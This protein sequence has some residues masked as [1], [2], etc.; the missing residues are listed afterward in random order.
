MATPAAA[1]FAAV[2]PATDGV[3]SK[4]QRR[5]AKLI[6]SILIVAA[7]AVAALLAAAPSL[8][9]AASTDI[10]S[11]TP[12]SSSSTATQTTPPAMSAAC[13][14]AVDAFDASVNA[15]CV[16]KYQG[17]SESDM[18]KCDCSV[19]GLLGYAQAVVD[20]CDVIYR[21]SI[22][23]IGY[24]NINPTTSLADIQS[25]CA[26]YGVTVSGAFNNSRASTATATTTSTS[27]VALARGLH[28]EMMIL[29]CAAMTAAIIAVL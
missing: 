22:N 27:S 12:T 7:A 20:K 18:Y 28:I 24:F 6:T 29:L 19:P 17:G 10:T 1:S 4:P 14:A 25:F 15:P 23:R 13:V 5:A 21:G 3:R 16:A 9:S 8:A 11:S 26:K 2:T